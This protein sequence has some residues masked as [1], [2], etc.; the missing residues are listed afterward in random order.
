MAHNYTFQDIAGILASIPV[1]AIYLFAPGY[2]FGWATNLF[3]FRTRQISEKILLA[4]PISLAVST[5]IANLIGRYVPASILQIAFVLSAIVAAIHLVLGWWGGSR[6]NSWKIPSTTKIAVL[7]AILW[8]MVAVASFVDIQIGNKLYVTTAIWDHAVRVAFLHSAIRSGPPLKNPFCYLGRAPTARYYYYWYVLCSYPA[9]LT[10]LSARYVLY[11]SSVWAGFCLAT[12]IPLYLKHFSEVREGLR[13]KAVLGIALLGVTGLDILPTLYEF[14]LS[15][16]AYADMEWWDRVQVT[17]WLDALLWVPHHVAALVACLVGFLALWSVRR[18]TEREEPSIRPR[19]I[20][21]SFAAMAFAAAAGLSIYVTLAFAIFLVCWGIRLLVQRNWTEFVQYLATGFVTVLL[22][23]PY[24]HDLLSSLPAAS[25]SG[26]GA[27][28]VHF[29]IELALREL[30]VS[31][32]V[33]HLRT[34]G[35]S[36]PLLV[37][38]FGLL[39]IYILEFGFFAVIG[40]IRF[41]RD[42]RGRRSLVESELAAWFMVA[43]SLFVI[44]F[45]KSSIIGNND[46]AFRSAMIAQFVLLLWG[47]E[48]LSEWRFKSGERS[49]ATLRVRNAVVVCTLVLGVLGTVYGLLILRT[50]TMLDDHAQIPNPVAWLPQSPN[51]GTDLFNIRQA[52]DK[53]NAEEPA[54]AIVQYNPMTADYIPLLVR[55]KFQSVDAFPDCGTDFGGD[56]S[57]CSPVQNMIAALFNSDADP[58]IDAIC[59]ELSIDVLVARASDPV[60]RN[61]SSWVWTNVP[62]VENSYI[63]A[64]RCGVRDDPEGKQIPW[65]E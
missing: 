56:A 42:L 9:R 37:Y 2:C 25:A 14:F 64:F 35:V 21:C 51:I 28:A 44:T 19:A 7:L 15:H 4:L 62:M 39:L 22:S 59:K 52:Y 1:F 24:L 3:E 40:W 36:H 47:A 60:W 8:A 33:P 18:K 41:W 26:T 16:N 54:D 13:K 34:M 48:F 17:S 58:N 10:H 57:K 5:I 31:L 43:V 6:R 23:V 61:R 55:S 12:S 49:A 30:P 65:R 63:R 50:Y 29:P 27:E 20:A 45:L 11:G 53:L 32:G 46:L 38:P